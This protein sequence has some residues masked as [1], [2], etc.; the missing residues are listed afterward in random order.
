M[1]KF[2]F[3]LREPVRIICSGEV[4]EVIGRAEYSTGERSYLLRY[5]QANGIACEAWWSESALT[6]V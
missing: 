1:P 5:K 3:E 6:L 4:G 2:H